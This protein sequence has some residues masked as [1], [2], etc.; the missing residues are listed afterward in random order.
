ML[1]MV[2]THPK[3]DCVCD[4]ADAEPKVI[5]LLPILRWSKPWTALLCINMLIKTFKLSGNRAGSLWRF[6]CR[7][8]TSPW[9]KSSRV[10][11]HH[12]PATTT[13]K[14]SNEDFNSK[15]PFFKK[16]FSLRKLA[17][18]H[19]TL[20]TQPPKSQ[21]EEPGEAEIRG[22]WNSLGA[23]NSLSN[24][25]EAGTLRPRL[26]IHHQGVQLVLPGSQRRIQSSGGGSQ[27]HVNAAPAWE[28]WAGRGASK[29]TPP[30]LGWT[31]H[32]AASQ[33]TITP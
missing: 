19:C 18:H 3:S 11:D 2:A 31:L 8:K 22:S 29:A 25:A 13:N 9:P 5:I 33:V 1:W 16:Y 27:S 24:E 28:A 23:A 10:Y 20:C 12:K 6:V 14:F 26:V 17:G 4:N 30:L 32:P 21:R 15:I 7:Y